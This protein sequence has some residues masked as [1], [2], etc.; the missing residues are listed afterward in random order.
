[1]AQKIMKQVLGNNANIGSSANIKQLWKEVNGVL[2]KV[3]D[4]TDVF[5]TLNSHL[6]ANRPIIVGVDYKLGHPENSDQ[7][8]DHFIVIHGRGYD[9]AKGQYYYNYVE[10]GRYAESAN[11]AIAD[12]N[13]LYYDSSEGTFTGKRWKGDKTYK[14]TQIRPNK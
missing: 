14:L 13:R 11:N 1:M 8:T 9:S 3:G 12:S 2:T 4:A 10:T 5:N 7:T 6:D